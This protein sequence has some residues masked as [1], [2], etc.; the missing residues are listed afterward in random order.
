ML[1]S[2]SREIL[3]ILSFPYW[4]VC[5]SVGAEQLICAVK[6]MASVE[7][8]ILE[9][10]PM[11]F[12]QVLGMAEWWHVQCMVHTRVQDEA[13]AKLNGHMQATT[14]RDNVDSWCAWFWAPYRIISVVQEALS[15]EACL[16][17]AGH[18]NLKESTES[19]IVPENGIPLDPAP[20]GVWIHTESGFHTISIVS[21]CLSKVLKP[22]LDS[23]TQIPQREGGQPRPDCVPLSS[24][25]QLLFQ[26]PV[27]KA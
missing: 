21:I 5:V 13:A 3:K 2:D 15:R 8:H 24:C 14:A 18:R 12:R 23:H 17:F 19:V 7:Y 20:K 26:I 1:R 11:C 4:N 16:P 22:W 10:E 6:T 27:S 25:S 9:A